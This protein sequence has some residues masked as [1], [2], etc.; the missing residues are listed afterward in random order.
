MLCAICYATDNVLLRS[1]TL[2]WWKCENN[3]TNKPVKRTAQPSRRANVSFRA[4]RQQARCKS[5]AH[6][7]AWKSIKKKR[8]E[9]WEQQNAWKVPEP[10]KVTW[11]QHCVAQHAPLMWP[12][13]D[14]R[15]QLPGC[16]AARLPSWQYDAIQCTRVQWVL[17]RVLGVC[18]TM[19]LYL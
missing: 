11:T 5:Y 6:K 14:G 9:K 16:P 13:H 2:C 18:L 1:K 3:R 4:A 12:I 10:A 19:W 8:N 7:R 15:W 17:V